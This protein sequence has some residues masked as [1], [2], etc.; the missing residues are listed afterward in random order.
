MRLFTLGQED[1]SGLVLPSMELDI[2]ERAVALK[3]HS[4]DG[5]DGLVDD[6]VVP[7]G[8]PWRLFHHC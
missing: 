4:G 8:A 2:G 3:A 1:F 6:A 5:V 7:F